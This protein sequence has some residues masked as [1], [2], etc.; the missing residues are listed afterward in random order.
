MEAVEA[1]ENRLKRSKNLTPRW[2][3]ASREEN[4]Q[5]FGSAAIGRRLAMGAAAAAAVAAVGWSG[6]QK[7]HTKAR[8]LAC[9]E[10]GVDLQGLRE[11]RLGG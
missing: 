11:V 8:E 9:H 1:T 2:S 3:E 10:L 4:Q 7:R 6:T 5:R